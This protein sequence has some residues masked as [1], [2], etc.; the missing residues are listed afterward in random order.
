MKQLHQDIG[1]PF[2]RLMSEFIRPLIQKS[3]NILVRRGIIRLG[4]NGTFEV[5][6]A[7]VD[8]QVTSPL[9][10]AQNLNELDA[11]VRWLQINASLGQETLLL[12][13]KVEDFAEWSAEKLS[14][15]PVLVRTREERTTMQSMGGQLL[16]NRAAQGAAIPVGQGGGSGTIPLAPVEPGAG[17]PLAA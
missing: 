13:A 4:V 7:T 11:T 14:V 16:A 12:G 10:Q 9:A 2:G 17:L 15:D 8:V 6:G 1:S 3:L 5:N